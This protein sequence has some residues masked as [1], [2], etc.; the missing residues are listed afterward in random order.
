M[1]KF[2]THPCTSCVQNIFM[3]RTV[4]TGNLV[5]ALGCLMRLLSVSIDCD[6]HFTKPPNLKHPAVMVITVDIRNQSGGL[7]I[8]LF[9]NRSIL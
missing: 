7:Q 5:T 4:P 6:N 9:S 2:Y 8:L 1:F 3:Q